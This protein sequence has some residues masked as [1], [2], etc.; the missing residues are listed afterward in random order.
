MASRVL[1][2]A[3]TLENKLDQLN[4]NDELAIPAAAPPAAKVRLGLVAP[5]YT[6]D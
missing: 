3:S 5:A 4:L 2:R 6:V 1:S